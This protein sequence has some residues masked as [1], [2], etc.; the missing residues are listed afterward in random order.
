MK[1]IFTLLSLIHMKN[2]TDY[3]KPKRK[4]LLFLFCFISL[5][6]VLIYMN[7]TLKARL[8]ESRDMVVSQFY[9]FSRIE[10]LIMTNDIQSAL[11]HIKYRQ[12]LHAQYI[13]LRKVGSP[14]SAFA[15]EKYYNE[16]IA[17]FTE[18]QSKE[19]N[20]FV[21]S[22]SDKFHFSANLNYK[23]IEYNFI[24]KYFFMFLPDY[25]LWENTSQLS[26]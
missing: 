26:D 25:V 8:I 2:R 21:E 10:R 12:N 11:A 13:L 24:H 17:A 4:K 3:S 1:I 19:I 16:N 5:I 9:D 18:G 15:M 23:K 20:D 14:F 7:M 22:T 6:V